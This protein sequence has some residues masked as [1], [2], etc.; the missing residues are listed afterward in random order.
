MNLDEENDNNDFACCILVFE[1]EKGTSSNSVF[2][3]YDRMDSNVAVGGSG[4]PYMELKDDDG[5]ME[6]N[7]RDNVKPISSI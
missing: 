7:G 2:T 5:A 1:F 4:Q 6:N 3:V